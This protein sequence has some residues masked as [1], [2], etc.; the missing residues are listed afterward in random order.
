MFR[1]FFLSYMG[2]SKIIFFTRVS[3]E[4]FIM[5]YQGVSKN[6][7]TI[8]LIRVIRMSQIFTLE[9]VIIYG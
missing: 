9:Y 5:D 8:N 1:I 7:C 4:S 3:H 6:L 2:V